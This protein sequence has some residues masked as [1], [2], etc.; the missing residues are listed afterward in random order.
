MIRIYV[1]RHES[2]RILLPGLHGHFGI[3]PDNGR[4]GS[5]Q[6]E[7]FSGSILKVATRAGWPWILIEK[8]RSYMPSITGTQQILVSETG[9]PDSFEGV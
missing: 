2:I 3:E 8:Q 6:T 1:R 5:L 7:F 4:A 9:F